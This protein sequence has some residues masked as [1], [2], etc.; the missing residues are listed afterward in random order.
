MRRT[1]IALTVLALVWCGWWALGALVI[2]RGFA[3]WRSER[4]SDGWQIE[5]TLT[6]SGFPGHWHTTAE[7]IAV[8]DPDRAGRLSGDQL[9]VAV[10][11]Y[12]P[13][14]AVLTLPET[15]F[16]LQLPGE[17]LIVNAPGAVAKASASAGLAPQ[18]AAFSGV[19][20]PWQVNTQH[21]ALVSA[22]D[23]TVTLLEAPRRSGSY[24]L[25]AGA[26]AFAPGDVLRATLGLPSGWPRAFE[27]AKV[28][29][30]VKTERDAAEGAVLLRH[31]ELT[32]LEMVWGPL[33]VEGGGSLALELDGTP[34]GQ[35]RL[36]I[37]EWRGFYAHLKTAAVIPPDRAFQADLMLNALANIGGDPSTLDLTLRFEGGEMS[38]G[39]ILLG[40]APKITFQ[41]AQP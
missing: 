1:I 24:Q 34:A 39:T 14:S 33:R 13:F 16:T 32:A 30:K 41:S 38:L 28:A 7:Q 4:V 29:L 37:K 36:T 19:S 35:L 31:L 18:I 27:A 20:G 25:D 22:E 8:E 15:P 10:P 2:E 26:T 5:A 11:A 3:A 21:G 23:L 12:W 9:T 6:A 40:P 17:T